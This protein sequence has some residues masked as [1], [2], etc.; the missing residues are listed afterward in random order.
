M[1]KAL[2]FLFLV[3]WSSLNSQTNKAFEPAIESMSYL[4]LNVDTSIWN[5]KLASLGLK[6]VEEKHENQIEYTKTQSDVYQY[7]GFDIQYGVLTIIWKDASGKKSIIGAL[8]KQLK[9]KETSTPSTYKFNYGGID[10]VVG[11][12]TKKDK[13][14]YEM[15]TMEFER[16]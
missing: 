12:E 13:G 7:V 5:A 1:K 8:K 16:K 15:I 2:Y 10:Y 3:S 6:E 11:V 14:I 4:M 9:G